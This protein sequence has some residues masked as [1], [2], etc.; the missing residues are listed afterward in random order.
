MRS[1]ILVLFSGC[2]A[3]AACFGSLDDEFVY[4]I[5]LNS[6]AETILNESQSVGV[7]GAS[8]WKFAFQGALSG[9]PRGFNNTILA[10]KDDTLSSITM[11]LFPKTGYFDS[12]T[13]QRNWVK[14]LAKII[15]RNASK[16]YKTEEPKTDW[17]DCDILS[18]CK[19]TVTFSGS[20]KSFSVTYRQN[21]VYYLKDR[22]DEN[23]VRKKTLDE[24]CTNLLGLE[25]FVYSSLS[26]S[27]NSSGSEIPKALI[28]EAFT[29]ADTTHFSSSSY[30]SQLK[31]YD[32]RVR[33]TASNGSVLKRDEG[34]C[35]FHR[36]PESIPGTFDSG[37]TLWKL[38]PQKI[39]RAIRF[40]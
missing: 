8:G 6:S 11:S 39:S 19:S 7:E 16:K 33:F 4:S 29:Y 23:S 27:Y 21:K 31:S 14:D 37:G 3:S 5:T 22:L 9:A 24:L 34:Y 30:F 10:F 35:Q 25:S 17:I 18:P 1:V 36:V 15:V 20:V 28:N 12:Y 32:W 26:I 40:Q 2:L 13:D 38:S